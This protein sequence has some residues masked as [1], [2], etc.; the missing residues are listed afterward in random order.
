MELPTER[1]GPSAGQSAPRVSFGAPS[2]DHMSIAALEGEPS[3]SGDDDLAALPASGV[4]V[5]SKPDPE[6]MAM[7]SQAAENF[8]LMWNPPPRPDPSRQD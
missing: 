8:G 4:V 7:L 1:A 2:D 5:L 6:M 3:L